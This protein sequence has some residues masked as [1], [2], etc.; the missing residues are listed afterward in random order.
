V[1]AIPYT[2]PGFRFGA[3]IAWQHTVHAS[4]GYVARGPLG[5]GPTLGLGAT[6]GRLQLDIARMFSDDAANTGTPPTYFSLRYLF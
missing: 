3:D 2:G 1:N 6:T 5:S 4:V